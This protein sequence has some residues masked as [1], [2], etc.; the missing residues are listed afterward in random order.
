MGIVAHPGEIT[1]IAVSC[2]GK[3]VFSAGGSDLTVNMWNVYEEY[4][5]SLVS[6]IMPYLQLL[7]GGPHGELHQNLID[8]FYYCQLR[9]GGED[10]LDTR[11]LTG[12]FV[13]F[14]RFRHMC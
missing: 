10:T 14:R 13:R 9:H 12:R 1:S 5:E 4:P 3:Y 11:Y 7:D 6:N 8:Y 2:D